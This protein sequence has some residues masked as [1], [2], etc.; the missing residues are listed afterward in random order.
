MVG[1]LVEVIGGKIGGST[2]TAGER[3]DYAW[4]VCGGGGDSGMVVEKEVV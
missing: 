1:W 3:V 2:Q 4:G